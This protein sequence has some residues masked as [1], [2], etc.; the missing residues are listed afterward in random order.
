MNIPQPFRRYITIALFAVALYAVIIGVY[1]V[2]GYGSVSFNT[3]PDYVAIDGKPYS[4]TTGQAI[5]LRPGNHVIQANIKTNSFSETVSVPV[6]GKKN[7]AITGPVDY[8][9]EA[10]QAFNFN[11][12]FK[13]SNIKQIDTWVVGLA[14]NNEVS[15]VFALKYIDGRWVPIDS[16]TLAESE[17]PADAK[18]QNSVPPY[19]YSYIKGGLN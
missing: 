7:L 1:Y 18:L 16:Y 2:F 14:T 12:T 6:L 10:K 9:A 13:Y 17:T 4:Y 15:V 3:R 8:Q 19:I 11:D 5:K